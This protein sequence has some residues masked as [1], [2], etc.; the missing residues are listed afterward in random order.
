MATPSITESPKGFISKVIELDTD[1][2]NGLMNGIQYIICAIIPVAIVDMIIKNMFSLKDPSTRGSVE[3]LA[4]VLG[5]AVITIVLLFG[6]HKIITA[7]PTY[8]GTP[9]NRI[10]YSTMSLVFLISTFALNHAM[11]DKITTI[12]N[13]LKASWDGKTEETGT[14]EKN[15]SRIYQSG[16]NQQHK[17]CL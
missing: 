17:A 13:R 3:L 11:K 10:N 7:I 14:D 1:T 4:E 12:F 8:S 15:N 6:V 2:K 9:M 5:E 16:E